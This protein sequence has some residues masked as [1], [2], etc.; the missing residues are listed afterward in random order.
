[1]NSLIKKTVYKIY[2]PGREAY[3]SD[4]VFIHRFDK[5]ERYMDLTDRDHML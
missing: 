4:N 2:S 5:L 1:V 3:I